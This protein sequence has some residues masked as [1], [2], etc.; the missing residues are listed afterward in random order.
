MILRNQIVT[1]Q[2]GLYALRHPGTGGAP[3][4]VSRVADLTG[5]GGRVECFTIAGEKDGVLRGA[6]DCILWRVED[7]PIG[8][9][10]TAFLEQEGETVPAVQIQCLDAVDGAPMRSVAAER[11]RPPIVVAPHG[12]SIIACVDGQSD[13]VA[14]AGECLGSPDSMRSITGFQLEWPDRPAGVD[15]VYS[16]SLEGHG[17][18]PEVRTGHFCGVREAGVRMTEIAIGLTGEQAGRYRLTGQAYFSGGFTVY[19]EGGVIG[20]PSGFEH[21]AALRLEV[22]ACD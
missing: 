5:E 21:L 14:S 18:L 19:F 9:L 10:V 13:V 3:L 12:V 8:M 2:P 1:L 16:V 7:R 6:G 4:C 17:C 22:S 20:G 11:G 15:I